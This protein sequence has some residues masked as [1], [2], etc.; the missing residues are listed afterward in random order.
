MLSVAL[1]RWRRRFVADFVTREFIP[2]KVL[3]FLVYGGSM[4]LFPFITLHMRSLGIT[5]EELAIIYAFN[6]VIALIGPPLT[7]M[8][9]DRIGNFKVFLS[10]WM[11]CSGMAA[12][13][14]MAVPVGRIQHK[15]PLDLPLELSCPSGVQ[16]IHPEGI[17]FS[18]APPYEC[19]LRNST[20]EVQVALVRC[21]ACPQLSSHLK[22]QCRSDPS[23]SSCLFSDLLSRPQTS[24]LNISLSS[25]SVNGTQELTAQVFRNSSAL[26]GVILH[27]E[28]LKCPDA[29]NFDLGLMGNASSC[30]LICEALT[31]R[32]ELCTNEKTSEDL[33]PTV[34]FAAYLACR[35]FITLT[36]AT[37]FTLYDGAVAA[38]LKQ[39]NGDFGFQRLY[40]N[41]GSIILTPVSGAL[42]DYFTE[43]NGFQD[44]RPAFIMYC[45]MKT[46]SAILILFVNLDFKEPSRQVLKDFKALI[47]KPE[48]DC[49]LLVMLISGMNYGFLDTF[50]FW[51]LEDLGANKKLMGLTV[52]VGSVAGIPL[53]M[54][55]GYLMSKL[56]HVNTIALGLAVYVIRN[57]GYSGIYNPWWCMPFE[58]LECFTVSLMSTA[59]VAYAAHLATPSTLVTL[60]GMYGGIHYG[61]GR[62]AGSLV[63]GFLLVPL[64]PRNTFRVLACMC[65]LASIGYF[66]LNAF[67]F[68]KR[69]NKVGASEEKGE[70][71]EPPKEL[72]LDIEKAKA[73]PTKEKEGSVRV[74]HIEGKKENG[75][76]VKENGTVSLRT[77][78]GN[79]V[80]VKD[81]LEVTGEHDE[82]GHHN[83]TQR[84]ARNVGDGKEAEH[85]DRTTTTKRN[86][87]EN[88]RDNQAYEED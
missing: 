7:G 72:A 25:S 49:Y 71:E 77:E 13:A 53:L 21:S 45:T 43:L 6:P 1:K 55:S 64:G 76:I 41:L 5:E 74:R 66:L 82:E 68:R 79:E 27:T 60:Q 16:N 87:R 59:A 37:S 36:L 54:A 83:K 70:R 19:D 39:K 28:D 15:L 63:G 85:E 47:K 42:I 57:F 14:F 80:V 17:Y 29:S 51:F 62:G 67:V 2:L 8:L 35:M 56:G 32:T 84:E 48:I 50:L 24:P 33:N 52:T 40:H 78:N 18:A 3:Y 31:N 81:R 65:G 9:A 88:G 30:P 44:F 61:V 75:E 23:S 12:L 10:F 20:E 46:L 38:I 22:K 69:N 11:T 26:P 4:T 86:D 73:A 58:A 34:T